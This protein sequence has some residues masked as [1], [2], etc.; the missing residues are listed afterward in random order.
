MNPFRAFA[1]PQWV[2]LGGAILTSALLVGLAWVRKERRPEHYRHD[3]PHYLGAIT[4]QSVIVFVPLWLIL[5]PAIRADHHGWGASAA[6]AMVALVGFFIVTYALL[7]LSR[8]LPEVG[9]LM[10][11]FDRA[12]L[13]HRLKHMPPYSGTSSTK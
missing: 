6:D 3:L 2:D 5:I 1:P 11:D 12:R 8:V 9:P 7:L 4:F 13:E 10:R